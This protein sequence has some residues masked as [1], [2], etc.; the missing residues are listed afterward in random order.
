MAHSGNDVLDTA[1][2]KSHWKNIKEAISRLSGSLDQMCIHLETMRLDNVSE[3]REEI[4]RFKADMIQYINEL[5]IPGRDSHILE[6]GIWEEDNHKFVK[7]DAV[8]AIVFALQNR[9]CLP[10]IDDVFG[11]R[12]LMKTK[13][14]SWQDYSKF[15]KSILRLGRTKLIASSALHIFIDA[16]SKCQNSIF[17]DP[18]NMN[19]FPLT[20]IQKRDMLNMHI[21][22]LEQSEIDSIVALSDADIAGH[23]PLLC[24]MYNTYRSTLS[25]KLGVYYFFCNRRLI[26]EE[27]LDS[28]N[29]HD[30]H[31]Y[32]TILIFLLLNGKVSQIDYSKKE[33]FKKQEDKLNFL[34]EYLD[35]KKDTFYRCLENL[36]GTY[37]RKGGAMYLPIHN[38]IFDT[39]LK[40][41]ARVSQQTIIQ[42]LNSGL[43]F[44]HAS[45][46][47]IDLS[48]LWASNILI[49]VIPKNEHIFFQ[50]M[51]DVMAE[52]QI[53]KAFD[54]HGM[55]NLQF[56]QK[57]IQFIKNESSGTT[58]K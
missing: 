21:Q 12:Y 50:R 31:S 58:R 35:I 32:K 30:E 27:F 23:F 41:S 2:F 34:T 54:Y 53:F 51:L 19:S 3:V 14:E 26:H 47:S 20:N 15:L 10:V 57:F 22:S 44:R 36:T 43:L 42:H 8:D 5:Q 18:I 24:V 33:T 6:I 49:P 25:L 17:Q 40:F 1:T 39:L 46:T 38:R 52:R 37:F 9:N 45:F 28:L 13:L 16:N 56:R 55:D 29:K 7:T 48:Y 11:E 4:K